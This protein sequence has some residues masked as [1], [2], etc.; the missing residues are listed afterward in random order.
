MRDAIPQAVRDIYSHWLERR[1]PQARPM[2]AASRKVG[3]N[4][5]CPC[6]SGKKYKHCCRN[7]VDA[8]SPRTRACQA[9]A[10]AATRLT[11]YAT[12]DSTGD[13]P[14]L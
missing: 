6:G 13:A 12:E 14:A 10:S 3:R 5:P 8:E 4:E 7:K 2:R 1:M 11:H 9:A